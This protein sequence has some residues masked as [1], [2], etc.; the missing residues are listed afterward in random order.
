M[1]FELSFS[2]IF[3][4]C[5]HAIETISTLFYYT[6]LFNSITA[7]NLGNTKKCKNDPEVMSGIVSSELATFDSMII[8]ANDGILRKKAL[9]ASSM[10]NCLEKCEIAFCKGSHYKSTNIPCSREGS[11]IS[12][13]CISFQKCASDCQKTCIYSGTEGTGSVCFLELSTICQ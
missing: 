5:F 3:F 11:G 8:A 13:S 1:L 12:D 4:N 2:L 7:K 10:G 9:E 6:I